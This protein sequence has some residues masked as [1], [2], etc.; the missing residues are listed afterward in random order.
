MGGERETVAFISGKFNVLHPGHLRLFRFAREVSDRLLVGV[1]GDHYSDER[2]LPEVER[3]ESVLAI[4]W[5]DDAF[6]IKDSLRTFEKLNG[7]TAKDSVV[8]SFSSKLLNVSLYLGAT[9]DG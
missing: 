4:S 5:V 3:L 9:R 6:I 2:V 1:Y 8:Y 7:T